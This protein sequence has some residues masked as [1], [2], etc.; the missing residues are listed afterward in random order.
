MLLRFR[1]KVL[2][3]RGWRGQLVGR[4]VVV[5]AASIV[6]LRVCGL[7]SAG[8]SLLVWLLLL[9]LWWWLCCMRSRRMMA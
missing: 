6:A 9:L 4:G 3:L 8:M 1:V 7:C 5:V 2:H